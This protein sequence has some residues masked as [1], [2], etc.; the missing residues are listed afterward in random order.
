MNV[1]TCKRLKVWKSKRVKCKASS[2]QRTWTPAKEY[3]IANIGV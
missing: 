3:E 2:E 1:D